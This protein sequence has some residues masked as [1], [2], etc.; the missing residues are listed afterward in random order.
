[1]S[2]NCQRNEQSRAREDHAE[3]SAKDTE[4]WHSWGGRTTWW[5]LPHQ[6]LEL[7]IILQRLRG[8]KGVLLLTAEVFI[9]LNKLN[10]T[11]ITTLFPLQTDLDQTPLYFPGYINFK[12]HCIAI[13]KQKQM[14]I[15]LKFKINSFPF[16][17]TGLHFTEQGCESQRSSNDMGLTSPHRKDN[18]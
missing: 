17:L 18:Q 7:R 12:S 2:L 16:T 8:E 1:M 6:Q 10:I 13:L 4:W 3:K 15:S 14:R 5:A 9:F 11:E